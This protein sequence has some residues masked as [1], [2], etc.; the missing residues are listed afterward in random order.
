M[1][2]FARTNDH[3]RNK[4]SCPRAT[5]HARN[6]WSLSKNKWSFWSCPRTK[7][8]QLDV[9]DKR[10]CLVSQ[11]DD[12]LYK[13]RWWQLLQEALMTTLER[14]ADDNYT[15]V[16]KTG[17]WTRA[18]REALMTTT[19]WVH[20]N[21]HRELMTTFARRADDNSCEK[22][23]K[24]PS[25]WADDNFARRADDNSCKKRSWQPSQEELM[26]TL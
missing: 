4:L 7:S 23:S 18:R 17:R 14:R 12:S 5:D 16:V 21:P 20:D 22:R 6:K 25:P 3:A 1:T 2:T 26:T 8:G 15:F 19:P 11:N 24:L 13:K 9:S 10:A